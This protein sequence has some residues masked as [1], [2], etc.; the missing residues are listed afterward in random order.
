[1]VYITVKQKRKPIQLKW[2]DILY[3]TVAANQM[4]SDS[5]DAATVTRRFETVN[6]EI[7]SKINIPMMTKA[8]TDFNERH[9]DLFEKDRKSMYY[10]F[11]IPKSTRGFRQIDAPC[12]ELQ[13]ALR[14]LVSILTDTCGVLY[15]TAAY[16]YIPGRCTV[17]CVRKHA[18]FKSK[19]YLKTDIS[20]FFP[21]T[22]LDYTMHMLSMIFPISEVVKTEEGKEAVR[23][24]ISLGFLDSALPQ[25]TV[26]SPTLTNIISIPIDHKLQKI[27]S[28]MKLVYTR[29]ADDMHIS[30]QTKFPFQKIVKIIEDTFKEFEAPYIIKKE[31]THFGS[32]N[33]RNWIL[34]LMSNGKYNIT[35]GY[36]NKLAYK[37]QITNF[38][39]DTKNGKPW[40]IDDVYYLSGLTSYYRMIERD[41]FNRIIYVA[42]K[43][44]NVNFDD[45][46]K[47]Y[48]RTA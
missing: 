23:K 24:A 44:W 16:A 11:K 4:I 20:G 9:K 39:L 46:L 45:M 28:G 15:H 2:E 10:S 41:Y 27:L 48:F 14:E 3:N 26:L 37:G 1:M 25:G 43:K 33:G 21:S 7:L 17:D 5:D 40:N 22:T 36:K 35:V 19:W 31:K 13:N 12:D 8:F 47:S 42:N 30:G 29:Y 32:V 6:E 34:G 38:I 18:N